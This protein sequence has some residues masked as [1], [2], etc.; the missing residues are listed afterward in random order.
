M[1]ILIIVG[2]SLGIS[3]AATFLIC[4]LFYSRTQKNRVIVADSLND[5]VMKRLRVLENRLTRC[6]DFV[7]KMNTSN[8]VQTSH[9]NTDVE[10]I[11]LKQKPAKSKKNKEKYVSKKQQPIGED[12]VTPQPQNAE[13]VTLTVMNGSLVVASPSQG[14]YYRAWTSNGKILFE[15]FS[16]KAA[17]AINNRSVIIEPFC[18]KDS[19]SVP[20]DQASN[21]ETC[22]YGTLNSDYTLNTKTIIKFV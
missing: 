12:I 18:D 6:E 17:K 16:D 10:T 19:A 21:I 13:F 5:E 14:A 15:F 1:S 20:A 8:A 11:T 3:I 7:I 2:L 22:Q 4:F 9:V